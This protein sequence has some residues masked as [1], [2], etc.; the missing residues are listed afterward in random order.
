MRATILQFTK[1]IISFVTQRTNH[2]HR[3]EVTLPM[4]GSTV[5]NIAGVVPAGW[6]YDYKHSKVE[7]RVLDGDV[8]SPTKGH[9]VD[10]SGVVSVGVT[11]SGSLKIVNLFEE[12][13]TIAVKVD[14]PHLSE[15]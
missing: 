9:W 14:I 3:T 13:L 7:L 8:N 2:V 6:N 11:T 5:I 4:D 15:V 1:Q 12:T 10:A